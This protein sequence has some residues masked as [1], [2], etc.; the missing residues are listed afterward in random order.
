MT[1]LQRLWHSLACT[2]QRKQSGEKRQRVVRKGKGKRIPW[3]AEHAQQ[4]RSGGQ[5]YHG[6]QSM[7]NKYEVEAIL[8]HK[9][10]NA[11]RLYLTAWKGY[12]LSENTWEPKINLH[13][14]P[15]LLKHYKLE[16]GLR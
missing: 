13:H 1:C 11:Q 12:P 5:E 7:H 10:P 3:W 16:H 14:S 6:G 4:I 9:G 15:T 2:V 8:S